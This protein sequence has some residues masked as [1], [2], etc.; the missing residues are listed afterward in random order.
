MSWPSF[1]T[2]VLAT[3]PCDARADPAARCRRYLTTTAIIQLHKNASERKNHTLEPPLNLF[4]IVPE[5][6]GNSPTSKPA[7][8]HI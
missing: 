7:M 5:S 1:A 6:A 3:D 2:Y 4:L 8:I